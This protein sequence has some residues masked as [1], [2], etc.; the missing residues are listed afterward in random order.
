MNIYVGNLNYRVNETDLQEVFEDYGA[1]SSTKIITD[2]FSGRSKGF[3]FVTMENQD[4][5]N[6]AIEELNGATY[7]EREMVVNEARP[8]KENFNR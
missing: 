1:V 5:A 6:K 3:G 8:R 2:K 4:E 7:E